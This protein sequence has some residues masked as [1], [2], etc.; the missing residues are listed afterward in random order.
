MKYRLAFLASFIALDLFLFSFAHAATVATGVIIVIVPNAPSGFTAV[1]DAPTQVT[2]SW[3]DNSNNIEDGF[4]IERKTGVSGTYA[5]IGTTGTGVATY[6]DNMVSG[7]TTYFYRV[8]A[9]TGT[10]YSSY[11][12]EASVIT[13]MPSAPPPPSGGGGS[14]ASVS[15]NNSVTIRGWAYPLS[16]VTILQNGVEVLQT[17]AGPDGIFS[18]LISNFPDGSYNFYIY[19]TDSQGEKSTPFSF[20]V[21]LTSGATASVSGI[22]LSPTIRL[23]KQEVKKGDPILIFGQTFPSASVIIQVDSAVPIFINT[24]STQDGFYEYEINSNQLELGSHIAKSEALNAGLITSYSVAQA[25][26]VGDKNVLAGPVSK[27][28]TKGDFNNDCKVNL[29]DFSILAYWYG[30]SA[31]PALY[32]LDNGSTVDLTDFSIMVFYWTG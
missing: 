12:N 17:I 31:A 26:T 29:V 18:G 6:I 21:T 13:P 24:T 32:R 8:R 14:I 3:T 16:H 20:A 27:C 22:F 7:G 25:F 30:Q 5:V 28:P 19:V 2:L 4:S 1:P 10:V 15:T 9:F 23:D 11:S